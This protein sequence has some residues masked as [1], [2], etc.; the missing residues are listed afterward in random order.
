MKKF[1]FATAT[2][3]ER[4]LELAR[5]LDN[6]QEWRDTVMAW[7][8]AFECRKTTEVD[9]GTVGCALGLAATVW[10]AFTEGG[11]HHGDVFQGATD[12]LGMDFDTALTLFARGTADKHGG[13]AAVTPGM[14]AAEIR[15]F[16]TKR[17]SAS[18]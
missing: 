2:P 8:F 4:L 16:V 15:E 18:K 12:F 9:C 7:D 17:S 14:V 11:P 5:L 6:E 10:P 3:D 13:Y 1:N